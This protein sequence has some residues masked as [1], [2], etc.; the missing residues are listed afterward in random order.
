MT[1]A[2]GFIVKPLPAML[3]LHTLKWLYFDVKY[4]YYYYYSKSLKLPKMQSLSLE[5]C[6]PLYLS[7]KI[8]SLAISQFRLG[9]QAMQFLDN[10]YKNE[11][12]KKVL[13]FQG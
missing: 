12:E 8:S 7:L 13:F 11:D 2:I 4:Y 3:H 6:I 9:I 10:D 5:S 1:D